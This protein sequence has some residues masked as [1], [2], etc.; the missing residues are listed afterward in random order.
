MIYLLIT[1]LIALLITPASVGFGAGDEHALA[2]RV[3]KALARAFEAFRRVLALEEE[4]RQRPHHLALH[5]AG[6]AANREPV[7]LLY[8]EAALVNVCHFRTPS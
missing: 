8:E 4:K 7:V 6:A 2:H 1:L 5:L 3:V